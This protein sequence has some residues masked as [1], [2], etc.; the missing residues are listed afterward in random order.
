MVGYQFEIQAKQN[1]YVTK[2]EEIGI[3]NSGMAKSE[4]ST[5]N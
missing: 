4:I 5:Q 2:P 3:F 1:F